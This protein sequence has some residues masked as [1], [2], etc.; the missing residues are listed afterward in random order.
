MFSTVLIAGAVA[1]LARWL[2]KEILIGIYAGSLVVAIFI[3]GKLGVVPGF[4][5]VALSASIFVFS[6]TFI[7]TDVLAEI[8]GERTARKAVYSG[9]LIFPLLFLSTEFSIAWDPHPVWADNQEAYELTMGTTVRIAI[10]SFLAFLSAQLWDVYAFG[11]IKRL[12]GGKYLWLR[13]NASTWSSQLIDTVVFYTVGFY[14]IFPIM[15]LI[16]ATYLVKVLIAAIDTPVVYAIVWFIRK[17]SKIE[18][19]ERELA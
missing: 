11:Y 19:V 8:W 9:A 14:G 16:I 10:A 2:G 5:D 13:N 1:C 18:D 12:T 6:A 17:G 3:A 4:P 15:P 7:F